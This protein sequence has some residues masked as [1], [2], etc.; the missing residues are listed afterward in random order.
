MLNYFG[1]G[2]AAS[3]KRCR[4]V[5]LSVVGTTVSD[6]TDALAYSKV[7]RA[8]MMITPLCVLYFRD[9]WSCAMDCRV[10]T[11]AS[12]RHRTTLFMSTSWSLLR[13]R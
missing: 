3:A 10:A 2:T 11:I 7:G 12:S 13:T 1:A 9:S 5:A 4:L 8:S 6:C